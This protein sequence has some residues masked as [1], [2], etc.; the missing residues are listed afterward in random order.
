MTTP[1]S[2]ERDEIDKIQIEVPPPVSSASEQPAAVSPGSLTSQSPS[3]PPSGIDTGIS[4]TWLSDVPVEREVVQSKSD[5]DFGSP[6][7]EE[8]SGV[9]VEMEEGKAEDGHKD[10]DE[11]DDDVGS[12][13]GDG[14]DDG[15]DGLSPPR[16][17]DPVQD[18]LSSP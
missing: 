4:G 8:K 5:P 13:F 9:D 17:D 3:F 11:D 14:G 2:P 16:Y 18:H 10:E 1:K 15:G 6:L 12:L 7:P